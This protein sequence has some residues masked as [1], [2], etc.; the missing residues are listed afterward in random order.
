MFQ[1]N[2]FFASAAE[3]VAAVRTVVSGEIED[4][5]EEATSVCGSCA[6][7]AFFA[8]GVGLAALEETA[9]VGT[10]GCSFAGGGGA[11]AGSEAGVSSGGSVAGAGGGV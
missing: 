8:W 7:V 4:G 10:G 6:I 1:G 2:A 3:E 5:V 9:L 11:R